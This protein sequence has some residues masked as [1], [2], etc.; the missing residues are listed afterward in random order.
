MNTR[1]R[2]ALVG[3][4]LCLALTV[5]A[6]P[7]N[8]DRVRI[9]G[10]ILQDQ[11]YQGNCCWTSCLKATIEKG[12]CEAGTFTINV[13]G[14]GFCQKAYMYIILDGTQM[15]AWRQLERNGAFLIPVPSIYNNGQGT[16]HL[17]Y[18]TVVVILS[19]AK[20]FDV[21]GQFETVGAHNFLWY[22]CCGFLSVKQIILYTRD[23]CFCCC[24]NH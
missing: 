24:C 7:A 16:L 14:L 15:I 10:L 18:Q 22:T 19:S 2:T 1:T 13:S 8:A 17:G 12:P 5:F 6:L 11:A 3:L 4:A 23:C 21:A 20:L 9:G